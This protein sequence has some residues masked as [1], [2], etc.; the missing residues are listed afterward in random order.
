MRL[1]AYVDKNPTY[2]P[3]FKVLIALRL[4]ITGNRPLADI[5]TVV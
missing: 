3:N 2:S 5:L 4:Q 1:A